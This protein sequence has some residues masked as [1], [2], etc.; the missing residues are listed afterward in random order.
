M[1]IG[2]IAV[3]RGLPRVGVSV[4]APTFVRVAA[5]T[6][7]IAG[8]VIGLELIKPV[9]AVGPGDR[10]AIETTITLS[11][12]WS[13]RLLVANFRHDRRLAELL[14]LCAL[15]AVSL[16]DFAYCVLPALV[17]GSGAGSMG[18][19]ELAC[20]LIVALA[21]AA[22]AFTPGKVVPNRAGP[23]VGAS[24][25]ACAV[26]LILAGVL[27]QVTG[28]RWDA[29]LQHVGI[30]GAAAHPGALAVELVSAA[31]LFASGLAFLR[32][33]GHGEARCG[34]LAG[35]SFLLAAARLQ[36]LSIPAVAADWVTPRE[37]LRLAAYAMLLASAY[38]QYAK[39]QRAQ[40]SAAMSLEHERIARDLHDG[41]A[42]DLACIA[43]QGQR[44]ST[45]LDPEHPILIAAQ[46]ALAASRGVI[47]DLAA[48]SAPSTHAALRLIADELEHRYD[49]RVEVR[50]ETATPLAGGTDLEPSEREHVVRIARE[51]IVNAAL[52]GAARHVEVVLRQDG[53]D[54]LLRISDDGRGI[55]DAPR[56]GLGLRTMRARAASLGGPLS[57]RRR[58]GGG[59]ELELVVR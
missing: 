25:A 48:S 4:A 36:Y 31:T 39:M 2:G 12:I 32:R 9:H 51:A 26:A 34:L 11:A 20:N 13:A 21:F 52:H 22:A 56:A 59:T 46:H 45:E 54:L 38:W 15:A 58:A 57:A 50:I 47:A 18:G 6:G 10:A 16:N 1:S 40:A 27:Q 8:A 55:D 33:G 19:P 5:A 53:G 30:T 49:L 44:L 7:V 28:S 37:G 35:A 24:I 3:P 23:L 43:A 42:Q 17:G 41:L 29:T 14:L